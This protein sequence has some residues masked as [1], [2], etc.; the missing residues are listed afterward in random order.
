MS[1]GWRARALREGKG[2]YFDSSWDETSDRNAPGL[3]AAGDAI[4]S[5]ASV[6][7]ASNAADVGLPLGLGADTARSELM[8]GDWVVG[9]A[10]FGGRH[11]V[12]ANTRKLGPQAA[13]VSV[14]CPHRT[15]HVACPQHRRHARIWSRAIMY[16]TAKATPPN[17]PGLPPQTV[18]QSTL[19][20]FG[21]RNTVGSLPSS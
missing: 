16:I 18:G 14:S 21:V 7:N 4:C 6:G 2:S 5:S 10:A 8:L 17:Q 13:G 15:F 12:A 1:R 11:A 19:G 20:S 3:G 9:V